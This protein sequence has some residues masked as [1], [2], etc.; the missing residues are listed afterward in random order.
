MDWADL[1]L[2]AFAQTADLHLVTF[3]Q[4]MRQKVTNVLL[5]Q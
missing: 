3:D 2:Y 1:Y 4:A 5:L